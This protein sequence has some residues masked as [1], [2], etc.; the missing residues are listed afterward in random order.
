MTWFRGGRAT[1]GP[2][3][4][5]RLIYFKPFIAEVVKHAQKVSHGAHLQAELCPQTGVV[6][7]PLPPPQSPVGPSRSVCPLTHPR[8]ACGFMGPDGAARPPYRG[9]DSPQDPRGRGVTSEVSWDMAT[10]GNA[11]PAVH[12]FDAEGTAMWFATAPCLAPSTVPGPEQVSGEGGVSMVLENWGKEVG[13]GVRRPQ[14]ASS[15]CWS[16]VH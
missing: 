16:G 7:R 12:T 11:I 6:S 15:H 5:A 3:R 9:R 13:P 1:T 4:L 10:L 2:H 14:Q 8:E